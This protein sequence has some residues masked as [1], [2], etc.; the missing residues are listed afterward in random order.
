MFI[1]GAVLIMIIM[2]MAI[3]PLISHTMP[4]LSGNTE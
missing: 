2:I 1:M 3:I 4:F